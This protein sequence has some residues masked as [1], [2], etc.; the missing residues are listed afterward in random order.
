MVLELTTEEIVTKLLTSEEILKPQKIENYTSPSSNLGD[1]L[2]KIPSYQNEGNKETAPVTK[3][4][5]IKN[6]GWKF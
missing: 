3:Y 4:T 6:G 2:N 5:F 1:F